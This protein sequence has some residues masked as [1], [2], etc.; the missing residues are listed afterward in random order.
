MSIIELCAGLGPGST[1]DWPSELTKVDAGW[2]IGVK[3]WVGLGSIGIRDWLSEWI[4][5]GRVIVEICVRLGLTVTELKRW[6]SW[7]RR[8]GCENV[9]KNLF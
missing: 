3:I 5:V 7:S 2:V 9:K 8:E 4:K 1:R 6:F